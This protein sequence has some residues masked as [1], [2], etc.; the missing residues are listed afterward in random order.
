VEG[1]YFFRLIQTL[2]FRK[3]PNP[4]PVGEAPL[5]GLIPVVVL[6]VLIVVIGL[7]PQVLTPILRGGA[8]ELFHRADYVRYVL[9]AP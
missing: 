2:Y 4:R 6:G 9:G 3:R 5:S 7:F 1:G 8:D